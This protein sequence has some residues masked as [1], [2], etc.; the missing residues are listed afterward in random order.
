MGGV[1]K[2]YNTYVNF[3]LLR[4]ATNVF[5]SPLVRVNMTN[6]VLDV[7]TVAAFNFLDSPASTSAIAYNVKFRSG[8][9]GGTPAETVYVQYQSAPSSITLLEIGA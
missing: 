4:D 7:A 5:T 1:F 6:T 3:H 9:S 8:N 2:Q